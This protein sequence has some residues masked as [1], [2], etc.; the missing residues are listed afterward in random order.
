[1]TSYPMLEL[2]TLRREGQYRI[3]TGLISDQS[4]FKNCINLNLE[5]FS[6]KP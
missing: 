1:M 2:G 5:K 6:C 4:H 3:N